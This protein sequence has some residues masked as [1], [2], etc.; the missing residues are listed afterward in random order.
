[1]QIVQEDGTG[2]RKETPDEFAKRMESMEQQVKQREKAVD[3]QRRRNDYEV[4]TANK[5]PFDKA[6]RAVELGLVKQAL[7][8]LQE[9]LQERVE[10]SEEGK[11]LAIRLYL[12][13]G[14]VQALLDQEKTAIASP[15]NNF[16]LR[17]A[18]GDY[19]QA[20]QYLDQIVRSKEQSFLRSVVV[21]VRDQ[22]FQA[23]LHP[24]TLWAMIRTPSAYVDHA[25]DWV[26]WGLLA[27]EEGGTDKAAERFRKALE[28][29]VWPQYQAIALTPL[30]AG[31][32]LAALLM[33]ASV[34]S[35]RTM[36]PVVRFNTRPLANGYLRLLR[37]AGQ[38][39]EKGSGTQQVP[40]TPLSN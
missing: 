12:A 8:V 14:Q 13:T 31:S 36:G 23:G 11:E 9:L 5:A 7:D 34:D 25:D 21:G 26:L 33:T 19:H 17:A 22:T 30:A 37:E 18:V 2:T 28:I 29:A 38:A 27:L 15:W 1:V 6:R 4:T 40:R 20:D 10:L 35:Q 39:P 16:L 3:L 24:G 32:P